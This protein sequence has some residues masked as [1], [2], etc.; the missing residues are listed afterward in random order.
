MT[1][2]FMTTLLRGIG[3]KCPH[4]GKGNLFKGYLKVNQV[5]PQCQEQLTSEG[6]DDAPAYLTILLI[7]HF[8]VPSL[9]YVELTYNPPL[10]VTLSLTLPLTLGLTLLMLPRVKG[11]VVSLLW[12]LKR[13]SS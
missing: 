5:C 13:P 12:R 11:M 4:C 1:D 8:F 2:S 7:G 10:W 3:G 6:S 9:I